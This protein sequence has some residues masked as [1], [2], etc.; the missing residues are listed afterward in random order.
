MTI[1]DVY[2]RYGV[3]YRTT[4]ARGGWVETHC[5]F[6]PGSA[7]YHLGHS[8]PNSYFRCWRCGWHDAVT[9]LSVLCHIDRGTA[10]DIYRSLR[11]DPGRPPR[12]DKEVQVKVN[13]SLYRY[14]NDVGPMQ[15]NHRRYLE[16][17]G[18]DPDKIEQEWGVLGTGPTSR[19]DGIDGEPAIDYRYRLLVPV[20]WNDVEVS[21]QTRDVTGK[22]LHK[23]LACPTAREIRHH[24]Y[25]LYGRSE[26]WGDTG[27][28]VEGVTD[29]WRL[30][31]RACAVFGIQYRSEQVLAIA[32]R[33]KRVAIVFDSEPQAQAQARKLAAQLRLHLNEAPT[34]V[35][36]GDGIDPGSMAQDDADH[37]I[38]ELT[39]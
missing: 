33:F 27:V 28:I 20:R 24:K 30:G 23:Y 11:T 29:A 32:R 6:C 31:P 3:P 38:K 37:L 16:G 19:L 5:P 13:L 35:Y 12:T 34:I 8:I 15:T 36:L 22:A 18:F 2:N 25:I 26:C 39:N 10:L 17:R 21:F 1:V 14:P 7:D 4:D 9:T